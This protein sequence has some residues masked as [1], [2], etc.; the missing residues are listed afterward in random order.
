MSHRGT[1]WCRRWTPPSCRT[2]PSS[3]Q[4]VPPPLW[5]RTSACSTTKPVASR[6]ATDGGKARARARGKARGATAATTTTRAGAR[7]P[8]ARGMACVPTPAPLAADQAW[9]VVEDGTTSEGTTCRRGLRSARDRRARAASVVG[10]GSAVAPFLEAAAR[11]GAGPRARRGPDRLVFF[12]SRCRSSPGC[13]WCTLRRP[14]SRGY[15]F[16]LPSLSRTA[17]SWFM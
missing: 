10:L 9:A 11:A 14:V 13:A 5:S 7:G 12:A 16:V 6:T 15:R 8:R 2:W 1:C 4:I 17:D 3:L